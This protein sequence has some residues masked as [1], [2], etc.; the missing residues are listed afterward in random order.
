FVMYGV[1]GRS[2]VALGDPVGTESEWP[3]LVWQFRELCDRHDTWPVFYEVSQTNLPLYLDL[4]LTLLKIGEEG[5]V[6]LDTFS[7]KGEAHKNFRHT[8]N[9][10]EKAGCAFALIPP[11]ET[12]PLL[13]HLRI[14]S[15]AWLAEKNTREKGFSLGFFSDSY[16]SQ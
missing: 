3:E 14:V 4:G 15:D 2:W 16:L 13:P 1:E 12:P 7:I 5:R 10:I 11:T 9:R 8:I 6:R